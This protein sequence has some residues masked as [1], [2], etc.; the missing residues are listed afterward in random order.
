MHF[1]TEKDIILK[2][3]FHTRIILLELIFVQTQCAD[4][5]LATQVS[6]VIMIEP[7]LRE[8]MELNHW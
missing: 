3:I 2:L 7:A 8:T 1:F 6:S 5:S 4:L